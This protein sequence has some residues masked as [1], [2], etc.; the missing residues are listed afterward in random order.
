M[1]IEIIDA[2]EHCPIRCTTCPSSIQRLDGTHAENIPVAFSLLLSKLGKVP[3]H[4]VFTNPLKDI[5]GKI[6]QYKI[7]NPQVI[8]CPLP[9]AT[10]ISTDM[11]T[12]RE[13]SQLF[14]NTSL[15]LGFT[16]KNNLTTPKMLQKL[17]MTGIFYKETALPLVKF[18]ITDNSS[19]V[20]AFEKNCLAFM[21]HDAILYD[22]ISLQTKI[23]LRTKFMY[24]KNPK[25]Y[26]STAQTQDIKHAFLVTRRVMVEVSSS[27]S[28]EFAEFARSYL[29]NGR[30]SSPHELY[31]TL[32]PIGIRLFHI[33]WDIQN[34][35]LW[36]SYEEAFSLL[37]DSET[38]WDFCRNL[39]KHVRKGLSLNLG[40]NFPITQSG[41]EHKALLQK[42]LTTAF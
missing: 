1:Y 34:P 37:D 18:S 31:M 10:D 5:P 36:I 13:L 26:F 16:N 29:L 39:E 32:T 27:T 15:H 28:K 4:M 23:G 19:S 9:T 14:P 24:M 11:S 30:I 33:A 41:L 17:V 20:E 12:M 6:D 38:I 2:S 42:E 7:T 40:E 8:T 25:T 22:E 35:F 21:K 3:L